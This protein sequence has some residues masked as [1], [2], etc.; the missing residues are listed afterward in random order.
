MHY[1]SPFARLPCA[2][3]VC[4]CCPRAPAASVRP[5]FRSAARGAAVVEVVCPVP[6]NYTLLDHA[7]F[8]TEKGA[9]GFLKVRATAIRALHGHTERGWGLDRDQNCENPCRQRHH[10]EPLFLTSS[11][12]RA[13]VTC[14]ITWRTCA[15]SVTSSGQHS[16]QRCKDFG[17]AF[18]RP[19][20]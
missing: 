15:S 13:C 4:V 5:A 6:G 17:R 19:R 1:W 18:L 8:R 16:A 2:W 10:L 7:I 11:A 20:A 12:L 9:V 14:T 3:H